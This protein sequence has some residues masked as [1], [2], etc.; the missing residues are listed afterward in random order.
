LPRSSFCRRLFST[1][2]SSRSAAMF[3]MQPDHL[4]D[5]IGHHLQKA[6][7]PFEMGGAEGIFRFAVDRKGAEQF[8]A[9]LDRH[10]QKGDHLIGGKVA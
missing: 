1:S 7:V 9:G 5:Q 3:A 2:S 8:I 6:D 4:A 10:T